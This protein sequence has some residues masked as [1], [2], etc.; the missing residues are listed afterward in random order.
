MKENAI[1]WQKSLQQPNGFMMMGDRRLSF[2][3]GME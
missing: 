1:V 2:K 3:R